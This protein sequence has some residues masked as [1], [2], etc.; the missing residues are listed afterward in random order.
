M[1][2]FERTTD[3]PTDRPTSRWATRSNVANVVI[4]IGLICRCGAAH[5]SAK[6]RPAAVMA[7]GLFGFTK[8]WKRDYAPVF[9]GRILNLASSYIHSVTSI[10]NA[11]RRS[12]R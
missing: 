5:R 3:R 12:D 7:A 6:R 4:V 11:M 2:R 9:G 8:P 10:A 1:I